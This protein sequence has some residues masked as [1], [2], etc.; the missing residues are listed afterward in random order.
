[1][2]VEIMLDSR[3]DL[4][5]LTGAGYDVAGVQGNRVVLHADGEELENLRAEGW[6]ISVLDSAL[7]PA[8]GP[9]LKGL[10]EYHK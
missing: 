6:D 1:M 4:D 9:S 5:R 2:T 7:R 8:E 3:A 10:D